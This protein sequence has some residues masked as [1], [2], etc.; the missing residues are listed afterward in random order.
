M[1]TTGMHADAV[2]LVK[3]LK[4]H[5]Q[6][7]ISDLLLNFRVMIRMLTAS[8]H[9]FFLAKQYEDNHGKFMSTSAIAQLLAVTLYRKRFFPYYVFNILGGVDDEGA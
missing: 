8:R 3:T 4:I 1:A 9:S 5:L 6:V 7:C 2:T